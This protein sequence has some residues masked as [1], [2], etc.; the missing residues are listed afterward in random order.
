MT[1]TYLVLIVKVKCSFCPCFSK[2]SQDIFTIEYVRLIPLYFLFFY[3]RTLTIVL[4]Q[5][6][7]IYNNLANNYLQQINLSN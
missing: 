2:L 7:I 6:L 3:N 5:C 1:N 4:K